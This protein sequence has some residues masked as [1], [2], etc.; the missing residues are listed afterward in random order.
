MQ[1]DAKRAVNVK[2]IWKSCESSSES[3]ES[4][5]LHWSHQG[6]QIDHESWRFSTLWRHEDTDLTG[7]IFAFKLVF[8][9]HHR[10]CQVSKPKHQK[11][12]HLRMQISMKC[13]H[14][15]NTKSWTISFGK[16]KS[17]K[18]TL[19]PLKKM[20][21]SKSSES[22]RCQGSYFPGA[23]AVRFREKKL[24]GVVSQ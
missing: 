21:V 20:V 17:L 10:I 9:R 1:N 6:W 13:L 24:C 8:E 2:F 7:R 16:K 11:G 18:R 5:V 15:I 23:F 22:P 14:P 4:L 3:V 19:R 12:C